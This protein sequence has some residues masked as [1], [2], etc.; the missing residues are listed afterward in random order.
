MEE[1]LKNASDG[2]KKEEKAEEMAKVKDEQKKLEM[3]SKIV[4]K[5]LLKLEREH[6]QLNAQLESELADSM[7]Q[8]AYV[9]SLVTIL[10]L[11]AFPWL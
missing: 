10:I 2:K 6:T 9:V 11:H 1:N 5:Q 7:I 8:T 3:E 4:K